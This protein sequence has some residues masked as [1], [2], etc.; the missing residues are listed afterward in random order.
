MAGFLREFSQD[1]AEKKNGLREFTRNLAEYY[2]RKFAFEN[3]CSQS[4]RE[5]RAFFLGWSVSKLIRFARASS[6][7]RDFNCRNKALTES[8]V[9]V[10]ITVFKVLTPGL[11]ENVM[12]AWRNFFNKVY[13]NENSTMIKFTDLGISWGN[14]IFRNTYH[15]KRI[16]YNLE[17]MR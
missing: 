3:F 1:F 13:Q 7:I 16:W 4:E 5:K 10:I 2:P 11:E 9:I 12:L 15:D 17:F 6:H 14:L 8:R